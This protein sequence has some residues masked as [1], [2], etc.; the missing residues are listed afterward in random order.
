MWKD[1]LDSSEFKDPIVSQDDIED[2]V[3]LMID[4][5]IDPSKFAGNL[6]ALLSGGSGILLFEDAFFP[7]R[8]WQPPPTQSTTGEFILGRPVGMP[9]WMLVAFPD[10]VNWLNERMIA[11]HGTSNDERDETQKILSLWGIELQHASDL[12]ESAFKNKDGQIQAKYFRN[13]I[14][15]YARDTGKTFETIVEEGSPNDIYLCCDFFNSLGEKNLFTLIASMTTKYYLELKRNFAKYF[16]DETSLIAAAGIIDANHYIFKTQQIKPEQI[17]DLARE[18]QESKN[19]FIDFIM[20]F[21]PLI[22]AAEASEFPF[23]TVKESCESESEATEHAIQKT[24]TSY[25]NEPG[26]AN[27]CIFFMESRQFSNIRKML[28]VRDKSLLSKI[29]ETL[30]GQ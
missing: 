13:L 21:E 22:M 27:W 25:T 9:L 16:P 6:R 2:V 15:N 3:S 8:T 7:E 29:K 5:K 30:F 19:R 12:D 10:V 23:E 14:D 18:T 20:R 11:F 28:H 26:I 1:L 24:L 4:N 17:I